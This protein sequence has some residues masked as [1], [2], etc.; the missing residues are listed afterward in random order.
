MPITSSSHWTLLRR[1]WLPHLNFLPSGIST[2]WKY[3]S[4]PSV[5]QTGVPALSASTN[6]KEHLCY[7]ELDSLQYNHIFF[8]VRNSELNTAFHKYPHGRW[9][10]K[11]HLS[12]PAGN[13]LDNAAQDSVGLFLQR[14][15][16]L[17]QQNYVGKNLFSLCRETMESSCEHWMWLANRHISK[18]LKSCI[19][20]NH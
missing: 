6:M 20:F 3:S 17:P 13:A 1:A 9:A 11:Y 7:L 16:K 5:L 8:V 10:E 18:S 14:K 2:H 12:W 4:E 15:I 19:S